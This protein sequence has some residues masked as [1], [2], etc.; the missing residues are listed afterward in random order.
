MA[1]KIYEQKSDS[2]LDYMIDWSEWLASGE[3]ILSS[4]WT[5]TDGLT[6]VDSSFTYNSTTVFVTGGEVGSTYF[7]S[8]QVTTSNTPARIDSK[9][10]YLKVV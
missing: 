10:F 2:Q 9:G 7:L 3:S 4:D 8:C 1:S 6:V 5:A